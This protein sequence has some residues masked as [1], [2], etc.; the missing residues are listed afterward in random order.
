MKRTANTPVAP[1]ADRLEP[2]LSYAEQ[3]SA[4]EARRKAADDL[5]LRKMIHLREPMNPSWDGLMPSYLS[6]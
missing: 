1:P 3:L 2:S 5:L 4:L 6:S